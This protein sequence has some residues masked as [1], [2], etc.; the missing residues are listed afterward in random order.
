MEIYRYI[1]KKNKNNTELDDKV[2]NNKAIK[3]EEEVKDENNNV[4]LFPRSDQCLTING[5]SSFSS[6]KGGI[7]N[8]NPLEKQL[9]FSTA[10]T[11]KVERETEEQKEG[12]TFTEN[13]NYR[14]D[15]NVNVMNGGKRSRLSNN[16]RSKHVTKKILQSP[17]F[18]RYV[19][20]PTIQ[21]TSSRK[22]D[23]TQK[24]DS[25]SNC[26]SF[27]IFGNGKEKTQNFKKPLKSRFK[28]ITNGTDTIDEIDCSS[29]ESSQSS[30]KSDKVSYL[31]TSI[32]VGED[33]R[34]TEQKVSLIG[35]DRIYVS[36]DPENRTT[37]YKT[38]L[39]N[40]YIK[41]LSLF[42]LLSI[43][44][45][46]LDHIFHNPLCG[47]L[48]QCGCTWEWSGGVKPCNIY[49]KEGPH[50]PWCS[51]STFLEKFL[52]N[53]YWVIA[54][55]IFSFYVWKCI[56]KRKFQC[57]DRGL[58]NTQN[59]GNIQ[60]LENRHN[61]ENTK[62]IMTQQNTNQVYEDSEEH[63]IYL[64]LTNEESSLNSN[65]LER[66]IKPSEST[67]EI[68]QNGRDN[69]NTSSN[70]SSKI[71]SDPLAFFVSPIVTFLIYNLSMGLLFY[72]FFFPDYPY[73]LWYTRES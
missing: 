42:L 71:S 64:Q 43:Y 53:D 24:R 49:N 45:Y 10:T 32:I 11:A 39:N 46:G 44:S 6:G 37:G 20:L 57:T 21:K 22:G 5:I 25:T 40:K 4:Y 63:E 54:L 9:L 58:R 19:S 65:R 8:I 18:K 2:I 14:I 59:N 66:G 28:N 35:E 34:D 15:R 60:D 31:S 13:N 51:S 7:T 70:K 52:V 50:C 23:A 38:F 29:S 55:M 26:L 68:N 36:G 72:Y 33:K 47:L 41:N 73:L 12:V 27:P 69:S 56:L 3:M 30:Y 1:K 61:E 17:H 48:F 16:Y 67:E 62:E